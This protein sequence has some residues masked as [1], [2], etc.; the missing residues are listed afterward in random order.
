[1]AEKLRTAVLQNI[2]ARTRTTWESSVPADLLEE[3]SSIKADFHAGKLLDAIGK[4]VT[5]TG[6]AK[7][8]S[9]SL[10]NLGHR[11]HPVTVSRW[12]ADR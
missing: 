5:K 7:S 1:M 9:I 10:A 12:L 11:F 4:P 6:L 2:P 8:I 3:L